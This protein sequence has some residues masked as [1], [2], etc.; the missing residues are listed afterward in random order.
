M[1]RAQ[2]LGAKELIAQFQKL[3]NEVATTYVA[4]SLL[5]GAEVIRESIIRKMWFRT[6]FLLQQL[7]PLQTVEKSRD[8]VLM[9]LN[10]GPQGFYWRFLEK[11]THWRRGPKAGQVKLLPHPRLKQ[12]FTN[13]KT[14][15]TQTI[16]DTF[17]D[18][19][20]GFE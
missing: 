14:T 3:D 11:G 9:T 5:A 13:R 8:R 4:E 12:A 10:I 6:G 7:E 15:A 17:R 2:L 1:A 20:L 18:Y 16:R 19:M